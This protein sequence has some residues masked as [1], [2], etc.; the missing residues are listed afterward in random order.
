MRASL[1][2][3]YT[4]SSDSSYTARTFARI[5]R[6]L[7]SDMRLLST[8]TAS[9]GT[10][11]HFPHND[12]RCKSLINSNT[13]SESKKLLKYFDRTFQFQTHYVR[14][15][16]RKLQNFQVLSRMTRAGSRSVSAV[17][18]SKHSP[19][20]MSLTLS[21]SWSVVCRAHVQAFAQN[22]RRL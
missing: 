6:R 15:K 18:I 20:F 4:I 16:F 21:R 2:S 12:Y 13:V 10:M 11:Y 9:V 8:I 5:W 14:M 19:F 1:R 17:Q 3:F 22:L 7:R